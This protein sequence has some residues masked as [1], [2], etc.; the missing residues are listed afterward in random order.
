MEGE[1]EEVGE[2]M[3][4]GEGELVEDGAA[5]MTRV[6]HLVAVLVLVV[7]VTLLLHHIRTETLWATEVSVEELVCGNQC[8]ILNGPNHLEFLTPVKGG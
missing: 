4:V 2:A 3:V 5:R 6:V 8:L 1:A 7:L